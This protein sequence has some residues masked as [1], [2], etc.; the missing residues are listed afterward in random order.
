MYYIVNPVNDTVCSKWNYMNDKTEHICWKTAEEIKGDNS[1][2]DDTTEAIR[3][4]TKAK[5]EKFIETALGN[6]K[7]LEIITT[8]FIQHLID[9]I[10]YKIKHSYDHK[11]KNNHMTSCY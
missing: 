2:R 5:A 10:G 3:F 1:Y 8:S 11:D 7:N 4:S 6:Q 9:T